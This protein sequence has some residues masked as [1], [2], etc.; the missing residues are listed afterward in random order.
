MFGGGS[1]YEQSPRTH[2]GYFRRPRHQDWMILPNRGLRV[3][4][5]LRPLQIYQGRKVSVI[6]N[7]LAGL[8]SCSVDTRDLVG[9][10]RFSAPMAST[11][12]REQTGAPDPVRA[13]ARHILR[14]VDGIAERFRRSFLE[15]GSCCSASIE[16]ELFHVRSCW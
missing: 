1:V 13:S 14:G 4:V 15:D 2:H 6:G 3:G 10:P 12:Q 16:P 9:R 7:C 5:L 8:S 11:A